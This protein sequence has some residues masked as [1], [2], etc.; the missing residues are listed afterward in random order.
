MLAILLYA[1]T[2]SHDYVLDD[3]MAIVKNTFVQEG[4]SAIPKIFTTPYRAGFSD[5]NEGLYRPLS[6]ALFAIQW[7][8]APGNAQ[9]GHLFNVLLYALTAILLFVTLSLFFADKNPLLPF[10]IT[11]LFIAHPVHTE[12]V[13]NIKSSDEILCFLFYLIS[14]W[15][16][17]KY[18]KKEKIKYLVLA[19]FSTFLALLS[20]ETGV[21]L[22]VM[23]PL[24]V[25]FFSAAS[26]KKCLMTAIPVILAFFAY[27]AIR[28]SVLSGVSNL[29]EILLINNSLV[30]AGEDTLTRLATSI[31]IIGKYFSLLA[32][33]YPLC[34]DYSYNTIALLSFGDPKVL[35]SLSIII[36]IIVFTISRL[37]SR[38]PIA[39]ALIFIGATLS[40]VANIFFIIEATMGERFLYMPVLGFSMI[41]VLL[42][43]KLF[44][45]SVD[46]NT[47]HST[48]GFIKT[49]SGLLA[50]VTIVVVI[51][52]TVT[53]VRNTAWKD[54]LTLVKT[55]VQTHPN[56]VRIRYA[57]G[58]ILV[59]DKALKE[60]NETRKK[61]LLLE[62]TLQLVEAVRI[63]PDYGD[64]WFNLGMGY[65]E[66][67]DYKKAIA[68][69]KNAEAHMVKTNA[70]F[71][72]AAGI[73]YGEDGQYQKA[74]EEL[75]KAIDLDTSGYDA[76]NNIGLYYSRTG[77]FSMSFQM[78]NKAIQLN[79]ND[80]HAYYN[81]GNTYAAMNDFTNALTFYKKA[82]SL[83][84]ASDI[85]WVNL[86]NC[87]GVLKDYPNA[88]LAFEK[89]LQA[90]PSNELARFNIGTTYFMLGDSVNGRKYIPD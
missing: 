9:V 53:V 46:I 13:A 47:N 37:K 7:Q 63:L 16:S 33:P 35:L 80:D 25:Y 34:Y 11:L 59:M 84:P 20:K 52:G 31:F 74:I 90:N 2:I 50:I 55:D 17:L 1:N 54:N 61:Q 79:P 68:C 27:L 83:N 86:G 85:A 76:Y 18:G 78:L 65:K 21:T 8:L 22:L 77:N 58:S 32:L 4:I 41:I 3:D 26:V 48:A 49:N 6:I 12:V 23:A 36:A 45:R 10:V 51:Y 30:A 64:A 56:S 69:F 82:L 40:P 57:Y 81:M 24:T 19:G 15:S 43:T 67:E 66:L 73:A 29:D 60:K 38:D 5:R 75:Q 44:K 71:Y 72:I 87:Y 14:L 89:A 42:L 39:W 70:T 28:V 88:L 62:G